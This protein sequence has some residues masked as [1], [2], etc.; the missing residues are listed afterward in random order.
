[1]WL[2]VDKLQNKQI[3]NE[4]EDAGDSKSVPR[5]ERTIS[6]RRVRT[7]VKCEHLIPIKL[8]ITLPE[9]YPS[10]SEPQY[11]LTSMWMNKFQLNRI[12]AKLDD[13]WKES[14]GEPI[15]F[16]WFEWLKQSVVE[17]L[18]LI[19]DD[20]DVLICTPL[21]DEDL[22]ETDNQ[23]QS[24][25][26]AVCSFQDSEQFIYE[27]LRHNYLEELKLFN[28]SLQTCL[29][30]FDEKLGNEFYRLSGCKHHFCADCLTSMCQMHVK[31]GTIQ[32]LKYNILLNWK[33]IYY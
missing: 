16:S 4:I 24:K 25:S 11:T 13:I 20:G 7:R 2:P 14:I 31:E 28:T 23:C 5:L 8:T 19:E 12:C 1:M 29:I 26:R 15:L 22:F 30:C 6:G 33:V 32:L 10:Q 27:F 18:E 9:G 3:E 17:Y 21:N